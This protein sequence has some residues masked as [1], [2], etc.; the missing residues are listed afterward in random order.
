VQ[1]AVFETLTQEYELAKVA[2]AKQTPSVKVLDPANLPETRFL[3][4]HF[5]SGAL[6]G[7]CL[8]IAAGAVWLFT[9]ARWQRTA[10]DDPHKLLLRDIFASTRERMR[11]LH[12]GGEDIATSPWQRM[13][14]RVTAGVNERFRRSEGHETIPED[15]EFRS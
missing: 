8:A 7:A 11:S 6:L 2:E 13:G 15:V 14:D 5:F 1:E 12:G 4:L 9:L 10:D 3:P